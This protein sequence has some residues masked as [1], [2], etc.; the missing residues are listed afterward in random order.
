MSVNFS[1]KLLKRKLFWPN[2]VFNP[3]KMLGMHDIAIDQM[4]YK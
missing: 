1:A 3:E 2:I 4:M